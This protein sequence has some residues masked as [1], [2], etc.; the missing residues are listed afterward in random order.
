MSSPDIDGPGSV[1]A[2][3]IA[4]QESGGRALGQ[5]I[6]ALSA[7]YRNIPDISSELTRQRYDEDDVDAIAD[8][9]TS[10]LALA[11]ENASR[12][13]VLLSG[14]GT[15]NITGRNCS[16]A[17]HWTHDTYGTGSAIVS[18]GG[19]SRFFIAADYAFGYARERDVAA[20]ASTARSCAIYNLC[21]VKRRRDPEWDYFK[22]LQTIPANAAFHQLEAGGCPLV[23]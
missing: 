9:P 10:S 11:V 1:Q 2:A 5:P 3:D 19:D 15:S 12:R 20:C 23:R 18:Q 7:D 16:Y 8:A 13:R 14:A 22:E 6:E 4:V 21:K 17:A